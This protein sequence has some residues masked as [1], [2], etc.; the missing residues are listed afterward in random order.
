MFVVHKQKPN[1]DEYEYNQEYIWPVVGCIKHH[2]IIF[3]ALKFR[4]LY[5]LPAFESS[6]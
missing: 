6:Q 1:L 2:V 5:F 4:I 3:V